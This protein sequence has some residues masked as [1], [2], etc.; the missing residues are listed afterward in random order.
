MP[1]IPNP[2]EALGLTIVASS[3]E[4]VIRGTSL[5]EAEPVEERRMQ[6]HFAVEA[7]TTH[8]LEPAYHKF[9]EPA[10]TSYREPAEEA[11]LARYGTE[12]V[13]RDALNQR[14]RIFLAEDCAA[15][16]LLDAMMPA[17]EPPAEL[18]DCHPGGAPQ[19]P[20]R[21]AIE[22]GELFL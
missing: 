19:T 1:S 21:M 9:W 6:Y 5:I 2:Y 8:P 3:E 14:A 12:P 13:N 10:K 15:L 7:L 18:E 22:P 11:F 16:S 4:I 20:L 17:P